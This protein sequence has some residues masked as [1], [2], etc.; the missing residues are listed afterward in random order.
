[1]GAD[2]LLLGD[3]AFGIVGLAVVLAAPDGVS[4]SVESLALVE[5]SNLLSWL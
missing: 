1:M 4:G 3:E 2:G 5:G